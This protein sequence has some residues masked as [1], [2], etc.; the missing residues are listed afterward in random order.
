V[1]ICPPLVIA[2]EAIE[3]SVEVLREAFAEAT[4]PPAAVA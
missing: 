4:H 1:K 2:E 3:E